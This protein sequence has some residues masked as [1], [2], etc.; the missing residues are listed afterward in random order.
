MPASRTTTRVAFG[1]ALAAALALTGWGWLEILQRDE[2]AT[3][4]RRVTWL[5]PDGAPLQGADGA[6]A[7]GGAP[8][9]DGGD[10]KLSALVVGGS[11]WTTCA[12]P[13]NGPAGLARIDVA[14]GLGRLAWPVPAELPLVWSVAALPHPDRPWLG[15]VYRARVDGGD[16][17]TAAVAGPDGW[18]AP[19]AA[20]PGGTN[21]RILGLGWAGERFEVALVPTT[22]A[23]PYGHE[24]GALVVAIAAGQPP[25]PRDVPRGRLCTR[26]GLCQLLAAARPSPDGPWQ[27]VVDSAP[28][29]EP[30]VTWRVTEDGA[31]REA[32]PEHPGHA[33]EVDGTAVG[34]LDL[35][36]AMARFRL[37][38][39]GLLE[40]R[41]PLVDPEGAHLTGG[42]FHSHAGRLRI[43]PHRIQISETTIATYLPYGD[44]LAGLFYERREAEDDELLLSGLG[45]GVEPVAPEHVVARTFSYSCGSLYRGVLVPRDPGGWWLASPDGCYVALSQDL[46][47]ADPLGVVEHLLRRG[48]ICIDW[49][50]PGHVVHLA[51]VL[52]GLPVALL[53]GA[54]VARLRR[55]KG[56]RLASHLLVATALYVLPG[57]WFA[58]RLAEILR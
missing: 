29:G 49:R 33:L 39:D 26:G 45:G 9:S 53:L 38:P 37:T 27:F 51:W 54:A 12:R 32:L 3:G 14:E 30:R 22:A 24:A 41:Q 7:Q 8:C 28:S 31:V 25:A 4:A 52:F 40:P 16:A 36:N 15:Y 55:R 56:A 17:L 18:L 34:L 48:S 42:Y 1:V 58:T 13:A 46:E 44:A 35:E 43:D 5:G 6:G 11:V 10:T 2:W 57:L 47:R 50:E 20:L 23:D 21:T 19:P